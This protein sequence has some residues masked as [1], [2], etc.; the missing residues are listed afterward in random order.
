MLKVTGITSA[1]IGHK[2]FNMVLEYNNIEIMVNKR[3]HGNGINRVL[4]DNILNFCKDN[5][6]G[7]V[8]TSDHGSHNGTSIN[9]IM[10]K[11]GLP[12]IVTDHHLF[13]EEEAPL[14]ADAFINPQRYENTILKDMTGTGVLYF[15]LLHAKLMK[16]ELSEDIAN[17]AYYLLTYVGLTLISDCMDLKNYINRK[18]VI[19]M[20]IDLNS[21]SIQHDPFWE[22][23]IRENSNTYLI[24]ETTLGY[25]VIPLLNS[26][27]RVADARLSYEV[28]MSPS[29]DVAVMLFNDIKEINKGR[30]DL[31][32]K[33]V[34]S[35]KKEEYTDG[36][37]KVMMVEDSDGVQGIIAN[38]IMYDDNYKIVIVFTKQR[39]HDGYVYVGSGRSQEE[40]LNLGDVVSTISEKSDIIIQHGGHAKAIGIKMKPELKEFYNLLKEEVSKQKVVKKKTTY[41]EDYLFS[42]KKL[43][44]TMFDIINGGPYGIGYEKPVF[45]SDFYIESFRIY[46]RSN[47]LLSFKVKFSKNA[48][49][50]MGVFYSIKRSE[51]EEVEEK[52]KTTKYIR[53]TYSFN[54]NSFRNKN[55]ILLQP[56]KLLFK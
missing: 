45:C 9:E 35:N 34:V 8:I 2:L 51:L 37:I 36:V 29:Y 12:V 50:T 13:T 40:G 22:M 46:K 5:D 52:L 53:M 27:G 48:V 4:T 47:I 31:Q 18:I 54:V 11:T 33:A 20:L 28:M 19:K 21:K 16:D 38:N 25:N 15:V 7:V 24:D 56:S 44:L 55:K 17:K 14:N 32:T 41:V 39:R 6:V 23:I 3:E 1:A 30:K 42:T 26:P 43:L 49:S 10:E